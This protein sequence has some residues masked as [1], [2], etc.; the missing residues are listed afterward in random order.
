MYIKSK[1]MHRFPSTY[2][3][4]AIS[5]PSQPAPEIAIN[6]LAFYNARLIL[7]T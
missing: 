3:C 2:F 1:L 6:S 4:I 7:T 5:H